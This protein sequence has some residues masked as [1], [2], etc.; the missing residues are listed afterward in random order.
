MY[1]LIRAWAKAL[2]AQVVI[3]PMTIKYNSFLIYIFDIC[4]STFV[5]CHCSCS[6]SILSNDNQTR[7]RAAA[8]K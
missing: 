4:S 1:A 3:P 2:L 8:F 7:R 6:V 5:G